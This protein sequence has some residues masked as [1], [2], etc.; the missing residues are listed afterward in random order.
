M[1]LFIGSYARIRSYETVQ[2]DFSAM[3]AT[4]VAPD[5]LHLTYAFFPKV[6]DPAP[7]LKT[8]HSLP[9]KKASPP[10]RGL[11]SF[12][13]T[14]LYAGI[15][16]ETVAFNARLI[17]QAFKLSMQTFHPH[18]TLARIK[19]CDPSSLKEVLAGYEGKELGILDSEI[20]LI[21]STLTSQGPLY[22][23]IG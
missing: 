9:L 4:W 13:D 3:K 19:R 18:I 6:S 11:G 16:S 20:L 7:L 23:A 22:E 2:D 1:R 21:R 17:R 12:D 10:L 14:I 15:D 5:N 8:L